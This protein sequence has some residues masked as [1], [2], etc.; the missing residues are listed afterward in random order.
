MRVDA[1]T[2]VRFPVERNDGSAGTTSSGFSALLASEATRSNAEA[3]PTEPDFSAMT[4][5]DLFD[6]MNGEIR[7]G[8]MSLEESSVF[9]GMTVKISASNGLPVDMA[10]DATRMDFALKAREGIAY[11]L[12]HYD[13][14]GAER[15]QWALETMQQASGGIAR[16]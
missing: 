10:T 7:N 2:S 12:S 14:E 5:Q 3:S 1:G 15:L 4:R 6:W 13:P 8:S 9:L 16:A 11:C